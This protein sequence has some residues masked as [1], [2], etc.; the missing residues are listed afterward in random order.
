MPALRADTAALALGLAAA[1][2]LTYDLAPGGG[3]LAW[4]AG[5]LA[6]FALAFA[7]SPGRPVR[8]AAG[9][10]AACC[11]LALSGLEIGVLQV[12]AA[13]ADRLAGA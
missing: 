1:A 7:A 8:R 2:A 10:F 13:V 6:A 4:P 5:A 11:V 9:A 12:A 3:R